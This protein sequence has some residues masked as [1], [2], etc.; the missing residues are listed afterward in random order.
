M[1]T[2][3]PGDYCSLEDKSTDDFRVRKFADQRQVPS[4]GN[5][6]WVFKQPHEYKSTVHESYFHSNIKKVIS[7]IH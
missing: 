6:V 3:E 4:P 2:Q 5:P 7:L 1:I